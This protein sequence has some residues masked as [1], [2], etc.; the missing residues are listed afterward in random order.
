M[1]DKA[2]VTTTFFFLNSVELL[3]CIDIQSTFSGYFCAFLVIYLTRPPWNM[4]GVKSCLV[5][6]RGDI[7]EVM[8]RLRS[9]FFM[10]VQ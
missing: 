3:L 10:L 6:S 2:N 9:N 1:I 8:M 7:W 4:T 5:E